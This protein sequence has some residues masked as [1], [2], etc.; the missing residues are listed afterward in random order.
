MHAVRFC[1][2]L[3][4]TAKC[5]GHNVIQMKKKAR[6]DNLQYEQRKEVGKIV[7]SYL[8]VEKMGEDF[9]SDKFLSK[10]TI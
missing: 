2:G 3:D 6:F 8:W 5:M 7:I 1:L 4:S 10:W 9:N